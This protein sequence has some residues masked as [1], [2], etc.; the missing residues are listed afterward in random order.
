MFER[1]EVLA[2]VCGRQVSAQRWYVRRERR[3]DHVGG[4]EGVRPVEVVRRRVERDG[5]SSQ[6]NLTSERMS[7]VDGSTYRIV[8]QISAG[9]LPRDVSPCQNRVPSRELR[10]RCFEPIHSEFLL[11]G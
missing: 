8:R 9:T 6:L 3:L 4:G 11:E 7:R 5:R 10:D 2:R 1:Y